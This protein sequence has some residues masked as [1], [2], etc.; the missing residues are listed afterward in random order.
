MLQTLGDVVTCSMAVAAAI[1][2]PLAVAR[3]WLPKV[4][5]G[6][7]ALGAYLLSLF[8]VNGFEGEGREPE[9]PRSLSAPLLNPIEPDEPAFTNADELHLN[10]D[11]IVAVARMIKHNATAA[12][13]SKTSTIQAG[14]GVSRGG[15]PL[16]QRASLI[17][18]TLFGQ[19]EPA[20]TTPI[21][22][23]RTPAKFAQH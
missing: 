18:D 15:S 5:E 20:V 9:P 14:F 3:A 19:P 16:Y 2:I 7:S 22:G 13:P 21:A 4:K 11:E 10:A 17:Y 23:R 6:M 1:L 12:K 8:V